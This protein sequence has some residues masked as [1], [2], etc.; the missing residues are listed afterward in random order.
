MDDA[1][2]ALGA[3]ARGGSGATTN[4]PIARPARSVDAPGGLGVVSH[5]LA[6][7]LMVALIAGCTTSKHTPRIPGAAAQEFFVGTWTGSFG[8][9]DQA[10]TDPR[11]IIVTI[12]SLTADGGV[13]GDLVYLALRSPGSRGQKFPLHMTVK[14]GRLEGTVLNW[15]EV[16]LSKTGVDR[17]EGEAISPVVVVGGLRMMPIAIHLTRTK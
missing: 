1:I 16:R 15:R 11:P 14:D 6:I 5:R 10:K 13:V 9:R 2:H 12:T 3:E 4:T 17:L 8:W 7:C